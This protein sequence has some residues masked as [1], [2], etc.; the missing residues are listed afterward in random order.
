MT[1]TVSRP[2][3]LGLVDGIRTVLADA[4]TLLGV[5]FAIPVVIL[6]VG[7]PIALV[8]VTL[9]PAARWVFNAF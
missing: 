8:M 5:V 6:I 9:L 7:A 3:R 4:A 1:A 2:I